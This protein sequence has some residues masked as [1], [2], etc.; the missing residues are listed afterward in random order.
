MNH[1][2]TKP[3]TDEKTEDGVT[4]A[5][6]TFWRELGPLSLIFLEAGALCHLTIALLHWKEL[7]EYTT[8][9]G[10][11]ALRQQL[12]YGPIL[13]GIFAAGVVRAS[14]TLPRIR[15]FARI[16]APLLA[17]WAAPALL[18][19]GA[20]YGQE[21]TLLMLTSLAVVFTERV[22]R[23]ALAVSPNEAILDS[24]V[25][26]GPVYV[27][28]ALTILA[29]AWIGCHGSI[30]IHHKMMT[31]NFDLGLFEN[32][33]WNTLHGRHG[34]AL[35]RP[36]FGEHAEF[37]L[38]ALLPFYALFPR[39]ET[40]LALQA[41]LMAGAAVPLFLLAKR[42]LRSD[43]QAY[44]L[45]LVYVAYPAVHGP[46]FYDF[47]FLALSS[48]FVL[49]AA[50]FL[51]IE[52]YGPFWAAVVLAM[53]CRE[54]VALGLGT[55]GLGLLT[56][57]RYRR[58]AARL[59]ALGT[60][61][62]VLVKFA[63]M[64]RYLPSSFA[65]YY[66]ELIPDKEYGFGAVLK[67]VIA[68]PLYTTAHLLTQEKLVLSLHLLAPL[69]FL[70][71]RQLRTLVLLL[72]GLLVIGLSTS[73]SAI[74][75]IHFHYVTHFVPY[76]FIA[77]VIALAVRPARFRRP[78]LAAALFGAL[79]ASQHFGALFRDRFRTSFHEVGFDWSAADA[80]RVRDFAA[81]AALIPDQA[82]VSAGEYEGPHIARRLHLVSI[83]EGL[84]GADYVIYS[85][86]SLRWGGREVLEPALRSGEYG[87]VA[88]RGEFALLQRGRDG[89]RNSEALSRL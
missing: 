21:L 50:Y 78:A 63:W 57:P 43:W 4:R 42:W 68:N 88:L 10:V 76:L 8:T 74:T 23:Y 41:I 59:T 3:I 18:S 72:P 17:L 7:S 16:G 25:R 55:V 38:Y 32:L 47:H 81:L 75:E 52:R 12:V 64:Q 71:I 45:V 79:I 2:L 26:G 82:S 62:F 84:K 28:T 70:P 67:T 44:A 66:A 46:L 87:L 85:G 86:Q 31:S 19:R 9:N 73:R 61:W 54:D 13:A 77:A 58:T 5:R 89:T 11:P 14:A 6:S 48:F 27:L 80:D 34:I 56:V 65:P 30:R 51:S 15:E 36:Y 53:S 40:L 1:S 49:W 39:T 60:A 22:M 24:S 37:L 69:A 20:Y 33:F 35:E 83:K 29:F